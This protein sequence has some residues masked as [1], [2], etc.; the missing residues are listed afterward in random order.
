MAQAMVEDYARFSTNVYFDNASLP[1]SLAGSGWAVRSNA[2]VDLISQ[3]PVSGFAAATFVSGIGATANYVISF[4]GTDEGLNNGLFNIFQNND[5]YQNTISYMS[6]KFTT[7]LNDAIAYV[8][9]VINSG[10]SLDKITF[11]G[12]SLG[13]GLATLMSAL[14]NRAAVVFDPAPTGQIGPLNSYDDLASIPLP[15]NAP[16]QTLGMTADQEAA[17]Y[18]NKA[19]ANTTQYVIKGEVLDTITPDGAM[20]GA[21]TVLDLGDVVF[22]VGDIL[23]PSAVA[24]HSMS[25][26]ALAILRDEP[27]KNIKALMTS[28][29][30][31]LERFVDK[32]IVSFGTSPDE[33]F[34]KLVNDNAFYDNFYAGMNKINGLSAFNPDESAVASSVTG[35]IIGAALQT[36]SNL[37]ETN[38]STVN[39]L[40][41]D[42]GTITIQTAGLTGLVYSALHQAAYEMALYRDGYS[43]P[44]SQIEQTAPFAAIHFALDT[45]ATNPNSTGVAGRDLFIG[46]TKADTFRGGA[47]DDVLIAGGA[48]SGSTNKLYGDAGADTLIADGSPSE[49]TGG[50]DRDYFGIAKNTTIK[51]LEATEEVHWSGNL[52]VGATRKG[53][54]SFVDGAGYTYTFNGDVSVVIRAPD[55]SVATVIAAGAAPVKEPGVLYQVGSIRGLGDRAGLGTDGLTD[56]N[57]DGLFMSGQTGLRYG[58]FASPL[59]IDLAGNGINLISRKESWAYFDWDQDGFRERTGWV[60]P[61]DGLLV[62]DRNSNGQIDN[63]SELFGTRTT[64]GFTV[65]QP[66]D[67]NHDWSISAAD[68]DFAKLRVWR[69]FDG[70]ARVDAGELATLASSGISSISLAGV[71][72]VSY[73]LEGNRISDESIAIKTDG[74][75][76]K[77]VDAWFAYSD[78]IAIG[79]D[80]A[81]TPAN[82]AILPNVFGMG[83]VA[84]L[85]AVMATDATLRTQVESV[86][87]RSLNDWFGY[88]GAVE[89]VILRWANAGTSTTT[90]LERF[91]D[92]TLPTKSFSFPGV[93]ASYSYYNQSDAWSRLVEYVAERL[94]ASKVATLLPGLNTNLYD[95]VLTGAINW[96]AV[97]SAAPAELSAARLYWL[98]VRGAMDVYGEIVNV[99][100]ASLLPQF[101]NALLSTGRTMTDFGFTFVSQTVNGTAG[102]DN[103]GGGDGNDTVYGFDGNDTLNGRNG[104]DTVYGGNGAD[105]LF[106]ADGNDIVYGDA[107]TDTLT[108]GNGN[109]TLEGGADN[110]ILSGNRGND[111]LRG[112]DGNDQ[113]NGSEGDDILDGGNGDD[114]I[115]TSDGVPNPGND[116]IYGGAGN[117]IIH[118]SSSGNAWVDGG[119]GNDTINGSGAAETYVLSTGQ[120]IIGEYWNAD[121]PGSNIVDKVIL[122]AGRSESQ[123]AFERTDGVSFKITDL[124]TGDFTTVTRL[125][126]QAGAAPPETNGLIEE[127]VFSNGVT[128]KFEDI[129]FKVNGTTG[130][131]II[132]YTGSNMSMTQGLGGRD[133][134]VGG[135]GDDTIISYGGA[136]ILDGGDGNDI[137]QDS[138][139]GNIFIGGAGNDT[140][141]GHDSVVDYSYAAGRLFINVGYRNETDSGVT[142]TVNQATVRSTSNI[143]S[144]SETDSFY[145][146]N[147]GIKINGTA[148]DDVMVGYGA[149]FI[150]NAGNDRFLGGD[151]DYSADPSAVRINLGPAAAVLGGVNVAAGTIKDGFGGTDTIVSGVDAAYFGPAYN[152]SFWG[153]AFGD[154]FRGGDFAAYGDTFW[155]GNGDDVIITLGGN[156]NIHAGMGNDTVDG[157]AGTDTLYFDEAAS[158]I[159]VNLSTSA[160]L[161]GGVLIN[162]G[163]A[164]DGS[165]GIDQLVSI[166]SITNNTPESLMVIGSENADTFT[167]GNGFDRLEGRGGNDLLTGGGGSD[168]LFGGAGND[169]LVGLDG[170]DFL[171]GDAGNDTL[172]G[173]AGIDTIEYA[174]ASSSVRVNMFSAARMLGGTSIG[175]KTALDGLGGTDTITDF[176]AFT[177]Q[178]ENVLGSNFSDWLVGNTAANRLE[179]GSGDD[180]LIGEAGADVLDGGTGTDTA[181]YSSSTAAINVNLGTGIVLDGLGGTDTLSSIEVIIGTTLA[182]TIIGGLADERFLGGA[183]ND[184]I[185]GANGVDTLDYSTATASV[186]ANLSTVSQ[187]LN[188]TAV[189][190]GTVRDGLAG[191]DTVSNMENVIGGALADWIVGTVSANRLEGGAGDDNLNGDFGDDALIGGTGSDTLNGGGGTDTI[192]YG[193][194]TAGIQA[195]LSATTQTLASFSVASL[196]VNDG[197]GGMDIISGIERVVG[198][199]FADSIYGSIGADI[200]IGGAGNDTLAGDS[201]NDTLIGGVGDDVLTGGG[202]TDTSDY[203]DARASVLVNL[204]SV[205][206]TLNGTA[207]AAN[208]VHDGLGG[209]DTTSGIEVVIGGN[210]ADYMFG[211]TNADTLQGGS[212]DDNLSGDLGDDT[213]IGGAGNDILSGGSGTDTSDY[214]SSTSRI[215]VNLSTSGQTLSGVVVAAGAAVDGMGGI[216][217]F[218]GVER[219]VG[220]AYDDYIY[221]SNNADNMRGEAG[222]DTFRGNGGND[223]LIGG[224]GNDIIDGGAGWDTVYYTGAKASALINLSASG[225]TLGSTVVAAGTAVDGLGGKDTLIG[226]E[227]IVGSDRAD[228]IFGGAG[229]ENFSGDLGDDIMTGG[230]GNDVLSGGGGVDTLDYSTSTSAI[231]I[232]MSAASQT[233]GGTVVAANTG[234]DGL[235]GTDTL[236][237]NENVTGS[238]F[239]DFIWGS[240]ADNVLDGKAG[241]DWLRGDA[242]VD[243]FVWQL[244]GGN[245]TVADFTNGTDKLRV[246]GAGASYASLTFADTAAGATVTYSGNVIFTLTGVQASVLDSSDFQF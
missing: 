206:Q 81:A 69:D 141:K 21:K 99:S 8:E 28:L 47:G 36:I 157:G 138:D 82:V 71:K 122:W 171:S 196:R 106:G 108:G 142:L 91:N 56:P 163:A 240:T 22:T 199:A 107:G 164:S 225:Q 14:Y 118:L 154:Y 73:E 25:L 190:A 94:A 238:A 78:Q 156:D 126:F 66:L 39:F 119:D 41:T 177:S 216:D 215:L 62:W 128:K 228:I 80:T 95:G 137:L 158:T 68:R 15:F 241:N 134:F 217:T 23:G 223:N 231:R 222:N 61:E 139:A 65:L 85:H 166:E 110:D 169:T 54:G 26:M 227:Q 230:A 245:D 182:D 89:S 112:G 19:A 2:T 167:G 75:T 77:I 84:D 235:G 30:E 109:D 97:A 246:I 183:G 180:T 102:I 194:S 214:S 195:N 174:T 135:A 131:D 50:A 38:A 13:G 153:S 185:N 43:L 70:D 24:L 12:H 10:V 147:Y 67:S 212:G 88:K 64:D 193:S 114:I 146:L 204:S 243:Y 48:T 76:V 72:S 151:V 127:F 63:G 132:N 117:D 34:R 17:F 49:L 188:G 226:I 1:L 219:I 232:N 44:L 210:Q 211:S 4:R 209:V 16:I 96:T 59:V 203:S 90:A 7:Q 165:N 242:G 11:T 123:I 124:V 79:P 53:S 181:D 6:S 129:V 198:S 87:A 168:T 93:T 37:A 57:T 92:T 18:H 120:D 161:I 125:A 239:G 130:N 178:I 187:T 143:A 35:G 74:S 213:L 116:R 233:L 162:A 101:N 45:S 160:Q 208:R 224:A 104:D 5:W 60:A 145:S 176:G 31:M 121:Q 140:I 173:G 218:V 111:I 201:G 9:A 186:F 3:N 207:V 152:G 33:F 86:V 149:K 55:G 42:P 40:G 205:S 175:A 144:I 115:Y 236:S 159:R 103:I 98:D 27:G 133:W 29:P 83:K 113:L 234:L 202:G 46:G 105:N 184:T 51:D 170:D 32:N 150:G 197:I 237:G 221:G 192:D 148:Q 191:I 229:S 52:L 200:L 20:P 58:L 155:A 100:G 172:N 244:G 136:D 189:D 220:S 179:G